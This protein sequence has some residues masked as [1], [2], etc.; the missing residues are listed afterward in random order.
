MKKIIA[1]LLALTFVFAF[2]GCKKEEAPADVS[3][4][5]N[6]SDE[7]ASAVA[8]GKIPEAEY[9]LGEKTSTLSNRYTEIVNE[10]YQHPEEG[11]HVHGDGDVYYDRTEDEETVC[12][13]FDSKF[14]YYYQK[15]KSDKGVSAIISYDDAFGFK[16]GSSRKDVEDRLSSLKTQ[17]LNAGENELYFLRNGDGNYIVLR[18]VSGKYQLDFYFYENA[19]VATVLRDTENWTI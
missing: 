16:Q 4:V 1:I 3:S 11:G 12:Y 7:I 9:K 5:E 17:K 15:D 13:A 10:Q 6:R 18:Y 2:V 14:I 8:E 19:L